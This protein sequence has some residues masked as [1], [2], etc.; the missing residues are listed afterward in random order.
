[1]VNQRIANQESIYQFIQIIENYALESS[2]KVAIVTFYDRMGWLGTYDVVYSENECIWGY[3]QAY[4]PLIL[5][6]LFNPD[7]YPMLNAGTV[8]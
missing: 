2:N 4:K 8:R 7:R 5:A 6:T 1:M 3:N